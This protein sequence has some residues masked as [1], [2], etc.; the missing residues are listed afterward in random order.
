MARFDVYELRSTGGLVVDVQADL[1]DHLKTRVVIPL[2][3]GKEA[4]WPMPRLAPKIEFRQSVWSL[5]TPFIIGVPVREL[6]GPVGSVTEHEY[7][8]SLALDLLLSGV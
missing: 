7:T 5:A 8:I 1:L 2:L 4:D 6:Q 3:Q